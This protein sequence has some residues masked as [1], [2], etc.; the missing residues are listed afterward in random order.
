[1]LLMIVPERLISPH[2]CIISI[3]CEFIQARGQGRKPDEARPVTEPKFLEHPRFSVMKYKK[4]E[5]TDLP[6]AGSGL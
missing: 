4:C 2:L 5:K 6:H 3:N 1:M